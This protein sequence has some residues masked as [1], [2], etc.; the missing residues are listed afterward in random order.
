MAGG[1][2]D[3]LRTLGKAWN[4][5]GSEP[6]PLFPL[7]YCTGASAQFLSHQHP[8][9][10]SSSMFNGGLP[11]GSQVKTMLALWR[12]SFLTSSFSWDG[13]FV[14]WRWRLYRLEAWCVGSRLH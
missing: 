10:P 12:T 11:A 6:K 13:K 3:A 2:L 4:I 1:V 8:G 5:Q 7:Q 14:P 9:M